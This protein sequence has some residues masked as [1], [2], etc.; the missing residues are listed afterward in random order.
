MIDVAWSEIA[1]L[2]ILALILF[3]PQEF[4]VMLHKLGRLIGAVRRYFQTWQDEIAQVAHL[5]SLYKAPEQES[6]P[7]RGRK[8]SHEKHRA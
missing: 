5:E 8:K 4:M 6:P 2:A 3:G 7:R 1:F